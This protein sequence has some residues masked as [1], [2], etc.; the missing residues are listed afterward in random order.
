MKQ[1]HIH[2]SPAPFHTRGA[3]LVTV[4]AILV[5]VVALVV[6][7]LFRAGVERSAT[8]SYSATA[9]A[10]LLADTA[11]NLVQA[12]INE[13]T[14]G[15]TGITW[16]SQPGAIRTYD[17]SGGLQRL[18][19]LYSAPTL[20]DT[21]TQSAVGSLLAGDLAP[22]SWA[23]NPALWV[24]LNE[25]VTV[26]TD[27]AEVS[28]Y[29]VL[30]PRDPV[31]PG[32]IDA[33]N[34]LTTMPGFSITGAPGATARQPAPMPVRWLYVLQEGEIVAPTESGSGAV[35]VNGATTEN[36]IVGRI[37]FWTDDETSKVNVNTAG[38]SFSQRSLGGTPGLYP[39]PWD[40]P[41]FRSMDERQLFA[42]NQPVQGEYQRY[43]G[44]PATTD[45]SKIFTALN[46]T[47]S[48]SGL[49]PLQQTAAGQS[50]GF[51]DLLPRY[52]DDVGSKGGTVNTTTSNKPPVVNVPS[53]RLYT[54]IE[55]ALY[56]PNRTRTPVTPQQAE[57]GKFFLTA[58]SR[59]P[60]LTLFG[61]PRIA[62]WP[63]D[64]AYGSNPTPSNTTPLASTFDKLIA[65]C[66]TIGN[67][68]NRKQ[69]YF[70]RH[71]S[72]SPT[73]DYANIAR[74]R[75]LYAYL[76]NLTGRQIPGFGG[77][78]LSKY[79]YPEERNQI[80]TQMFDYIRST[81]VYDHSIK[82]PNPDNPLARFTPRSN[83]PGTG[84]GQVVPIKIGNTR[85]LG[86]MYTL[87][88]IGLLLICTADGNGSPGDLRSQSN[89]PADNATLEGTAL[90]P[91]QKR[92]QAMLIFELYSPMLGWDPMMPDI[93]INIRNLNRLT[94]SQGSV[95]HSPFPGGD[96]VTETLG[97]RFNDIMTIG[98]LN[99]FQYF[100]SR[101]NWGNNTRRSAWNNPSATGSVPYRFVSNPFTVTTD[102]SGD[103]TLT[104]ATS[105]AF[106][107]ELMA[108]QKGV[109][110][111]QVVQTFNVS[112]PSTDIPIPDLI[113]TGT[114]GT[115]P[116]Q[117]QDWW[118]FHNRVQWTSNTVVLDG[119]APGRGAVIRSD[120]PSI[121][122][123]EAAKSVRSDVVR[124]LF[125]RDGDV[126]L[127]MA[128]DTV[129]ADGTSDMVTHPNYSDES[130]KLVHILMQAKSSRAVPGVDVGGK[131]V[132]GADYE[133]AWAPKLPSG[134]TP[135]P[136][137][138]WD[139]GPPGSRDGAYANKPD[140][141][142]IYT[143]SG[144]SPYFH[145]EGQENSPDNNNLSTYFTANRIIPS[146]VMFGSLPTGV[147]QGIP[148]R[149]LL[150]RPQANRP[151]DP[152]GPK[153][154]LFLDLFTMPVVEP[155]A[156]SEPFSTA[157]KINMNYQ[158]VPFTYIE[159]STGV[160]AVLGSELL[161]RI[162]RAAA[163]RVSDGRNYYKIPYGNRPG[164]SDPQP[165][166]A[167]SIRRLPLNLNDTDGTLRQFR[168]K[169]TNWDLFRSASEICDIYLVPE[170][171]SWSNNAA[172]DAAWYG[173][174]FA[175][176]GDNVRERPYANIYPR[177]TTK[178][179]TFTVHFRVQV[180]RNPGTNPAQ[181]NEDTGVITGEYRGSVT[182]ERYLDPANPDLPD[183]ATNT[184][185]PSLDTFY[186]WR[187][188]G[189]R[190]FSP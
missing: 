37:A 147:Q 123:I 69:F 1:P 54:S 167:P 27:G 116:T 157:G 93:Q 47:P 154:H 76:Q 143:S 189:N 45:L 34:V 132:A 22:A 114:G 101:L 81:N 118:G 144:A 129:L 128:K 30:D 18:Y 43:P 70:Q 161:A 33:P 92:L 25:P 163:Q 117:A 170:G 168:E 79:S 31:N 68:G 10:Q 145:G 63:I 62:A 155:Y 36:P 15:E 86:R 133:P 51:F 179:N 184:T 148:W 121:P 74:N 20:S 177:L 109:T 13:A 90:E 9:D 140:E 166:G 38:G 115:A 164:A 122:D 8:A 44:H 4:L 173:N 21:T 183:H 39:A 103:G 181:W 2:P 141:G 162:P 150:F 172:A 159:R 84:G 49:Y 75:E 73:N 77:S 41:R 32:N 87:S 130:Y 48:L 146:A 120:S 67:A 60:E 80:L 97:T 180:L 56:R 55:E 5:L 95:T 53:D 7:F 16:A 100:M 94:F 99:G 52:N 17:A 23:S 105:E 66:T 125:S 112:F 102:S 182:L 137:W 178:S 149:T 72:T 88:E 174:D 111:R 11:V 127:T 186:Q 29:P 134:V 3:A 119:G 91:G 113:E 6:G 104:L 19:R 169:F 158:I 26:A 42:D 165:P 110:T 12:Q 139:S 59:A 151:R 153:D 65:F 188:V 98:G 136:D 135:S 152:A 50:S 176:I 171:Y 61:T 131:L 156:I 108:K 78:L 85:G 107:V 64:S 28:V 160:R 142:N 82:D 71:D 40:M 124:T 96:L 14:A 83:N 24:D 57:T 106:T 185:A 187:I 46:L 89:V 58:S 138:D 35:T 175:L 190:A 126:R